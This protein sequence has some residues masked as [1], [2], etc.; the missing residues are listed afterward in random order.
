MAGTA[1]SG[2]KPGSGGARPGTGRTQGAQGKAQLAIEAILAGYGC[3]PFKNL[4]SIANG[5]LQ[6]YTKTNPD[7]GELV[8]IEETPGI[9]ERTRANVELAGYCRPKLK[10]I[11]MSGQVGV[12]LTINKL[13]F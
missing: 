3:D 6:K 13:V 1:A 9:S 10:A 4:A 5:E 12:T 7:T 8:T 11:E 2:K